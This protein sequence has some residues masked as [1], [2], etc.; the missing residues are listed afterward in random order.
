M[1]YAKYLVFGLDMV[2]LRGRVEA[3]LFFLVKVERPFS[4]G[5]GWE[6]IGSGGGMVGL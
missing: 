6:P 1:L 3:K 4:S 5:D 2:L